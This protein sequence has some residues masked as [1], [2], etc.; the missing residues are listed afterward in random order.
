MLHSVS[1]VQSV[2]RGAEQQRIGVDSGSIISCPLPP[3]T[4]PPRFIARQSDAVALLVI[5][6]NPRTNSMIHC[7]YAN[8]IEIIYHSYH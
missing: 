2:N 5:D 6:C 3:L 4:F 8:T 7:H 1:S